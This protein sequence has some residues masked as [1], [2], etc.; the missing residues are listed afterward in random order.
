[1]LDIPNLPS[2]KNKKKER[3]GIKWYKS[4]IIIIFKNFLEVSKSKIVILD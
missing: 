4:V 3:K 2:R 1:M